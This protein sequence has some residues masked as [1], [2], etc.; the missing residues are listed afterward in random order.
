MKPSWGDNYTDKL[1]TRLKQMKGV[2]D[3]PGSGEL[4]PVVNESYLFH[5]TKAATMFTILSSGTNTKWGGGLFG[6][7]TYLAED[8][9]KNNQCAG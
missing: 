5:G 2:N 3:L 7:G 8:A 6:E 1:E 9:G 4:N